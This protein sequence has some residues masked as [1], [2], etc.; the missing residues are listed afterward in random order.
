MVLLFPAIVASQVPPPPPS[1]GTVTP[2]SG[3]S[4]YASPNGSGSCS[5]SSPCSLQGA[6]A[7]AGPGDEVVLKD[8]VYKGLRTQRNGT[9]GNPI[10]IRAENKHGVVIEWPYPSHRFARNVSIEHD[11]ITVRDLKV[12][13]KGQAW[14]NFRIGGTSSNPAEHVIAEGNWIYNSGHMGI[15][16][17]DAKN[18]IVRHNLVQNTGLAQKYGEGVYIGS[19]HH[20]RPVIGVEIYGNTFRNIT[21]N[22]IDYK[23]EARNVNVHHNIF[24][25]HRKDTEGW[26][27]DGL[28][29]SA[30]NNT[31][32][33]N[34]FQDNIVRNAPDAN[35]T[36]RTQNRVDVLDNVFSNIGGRNFI[37]SRTASSTIVRGNTLCNASTD[38]DR[39]GNLLH[40]STS[41]CQSAEQRIMN[42]MKSLPGIG[43][44][45]CS[46]S[47]PAPTP[48]TSAA[49]PR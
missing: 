11:Y 33:G 24:D 42:E 48:P 34:Y 17:F 28:V 45:S 7:K 46:T 16:I 19:A 38:G 10:T 14:D 21:S 41:T 30:G 6:L 15:G 22:L 2:V 39:G 3:T 1:C 5:A 26:G 37:S 32:A 36:V 4:Y 40:Q 47:T 25:G 35:Y 43:G 9:V 44:S 18:V 27:G 23:D 31:A 49:E 12:N 8:G 13:G 20:D 29:R